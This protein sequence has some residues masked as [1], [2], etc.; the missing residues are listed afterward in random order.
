[1]LVYTRAKGEKMILSKKHKS[2]GFSLIE[3]LIVLVILGVLA[4]LA[5]PIF[6]VQ[7]QRTY[8][9]E[10]L[11][12]LDALRGSLVRYYSEKQFYTNLVGLDYDPNTSV[13]GQTRHF[14]YA[15]T[16]PSPVTFDAIATRN[17]TNTGDASSTVAIDE[18][19]DLTKTGVFQ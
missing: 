17:T 4:G 10:A 19:G 16:S 7:I 11:A 12:A 15:V 8:Q 3:V 13:A 18:A 14:S 6:T 9:A 5:I 2:K 1:M